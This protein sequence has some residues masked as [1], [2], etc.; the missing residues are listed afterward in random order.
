MPGGDG[1]GGVLITPKARTTDNDPTAHK[2]LLCTGATPTCLGTTFRSKTNP[3]RLTIP[4]RRRRILPQR[5]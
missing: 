2:I 4:V 5:K 1:R 3:S